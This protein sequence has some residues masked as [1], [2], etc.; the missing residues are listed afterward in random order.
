[1]Y[2]IIVVPAGAAELTEQLGTKFKFWYRDADLGRSLFK[3]GRPNTGENWAERLACE[4]ALALDIPHAFYELARFGDRWGVVTPSFAIPPDRLV[5]GNELL[6]RA[7]GDRVRDGERNYRARHHTIALVLG[8]LLLSAEDNLIL[9]PKGFIPFEGVKTALDVFVGYLLFDAWIANQDRHDQ[10]W[11]LVLYADSRQVCLA[12]SFD[13]G[14][15]L[16]RNLLDARREEMMNTKDKQRSVE[17]YAMK[18]RSA[19]YPRGATEKTKAISTF[20]AFAYALRVAPTAGAAW[21]AR[22][23]EITDDRI[24]AMIG[25]LPDDVVSPIARQ[26]TSILLKLNRTRLLAMG[27]E[28]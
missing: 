28:A 17:A 22:L 16:A 24:D 8:L 25:L 15:G 9:P 14:S 21:L 13:H 1:M 12:P 3:E 26:F 23:R 2:P 7:V 11:G 27:P 5:H 6:A 18:A 19:F 4:L 20:D 10:N